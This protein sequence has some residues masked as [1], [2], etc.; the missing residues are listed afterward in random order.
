VFDETF[1]FEFVGDNESLK[2]NA[3]TLL[4]LN[5]PIH[6]T[7]LKHR[8]SEKPIVI[9]TKTVEWRSLLHYN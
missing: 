9:G 1:L 7:V 2:F 8:K 6:I 5:Q 4:K 3:A